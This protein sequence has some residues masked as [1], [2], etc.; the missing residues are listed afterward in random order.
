L[1]QYKSVQVKTSDILK[2]EVVLVAIIPYTA[3]S[4]K[5]KLASKADSVH[6]II[7]KSVLIKPDVLVQLLYAIAYKDGL[8]GLVINYFFGI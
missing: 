5:C 8:I 2:K 3:N 7:A 6:W 4:V 1:G